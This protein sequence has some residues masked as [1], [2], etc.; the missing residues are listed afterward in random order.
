VTFVLVELHPAHGPGLLAELL[1]GRGRDVRLVAR[2]EGAGLPELEGIRALAVLGGAEADDEL[3]ALAAA[4]V[5][6]DIPVL[7]TGLG[8]SA[9]VP[10]V[11]AAEPA[12]GG[13]SPTDDAA[14]DDVF[15]GLDADT[16]LLV[17][18]TFDPAA[19]GLVLARM[20]D[21]PVAV[22]LGARAYALAF[23]P[24][25][26]VALEA[27]PEEDPEA[28]AA[29]ARRERF[30]RPHAV[31]LLGRWVDAVVGRSEAEAPWGRSGPPP[32]A[33]PGLY[34]NPA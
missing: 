11:T 30:L 9:L 33:R 10:G 26:G 31:A 17:T 27:P 24:E 22:R 7:A 34:L 6:A 23:Q 18:A 1:A 29:H 20:G 2:H 16:R 28:A 19:A 8:A 15:E 3:R 32:E 14:K 25:L 12:L 5:A 21:I 4:C 13:V